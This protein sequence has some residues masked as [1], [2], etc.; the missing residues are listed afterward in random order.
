MKPLKILLPVHVFFPKHFYGTETY[1]L[2]LAKSLKTLGHDPVILTAI[3]C[4]EEGTGQLVSQ[5]H[6]DDLP[7]HVIDLNKMPHNRFKQTYYRPELYPI[8]KDLISTIQ[9]DIARVTHLINHTGTLLEVLKDRKIPTVSTLTDFFGICFNNKLERFDG[10]LCMGPNRHSTNCLGCYLCIAKQY[11]LYNVLQPFTKNRHILNTVT[12]L[13]QYAIK[14][15]GLRKSSLSGHIFDVTKRFNTLRHLYGQ[16]TSMVAPSDFLY[17]AYVK[18][19]FYP[20]RLKKINF[21]INLDLLEGYRETRKKKNGSTVFGYIGQISHHKGVDLLVEAFNR[22][23]GDNKKLKIF[24]PSDQ[25]PDYMHQLHKK[26]DANQQIEFHEP[27]PREKLAKRL[28]AIDILVIPS[29]WYEN[30]PLV[31]LYALATRTPVIATD[32]KGM[33]EFVKNDYNG[34]T[35]KKNDVVDLTKKMEKLIND[36]KTIERLSKN[37]NYTKDNID[38]AKEVFSIYQEIMSSHSTIHP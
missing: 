12:R 11:P 24:G 7:V 6:Y 16:Y 37:A 4:G 14:I 3:P 8:L 13:L 33:S 5:Y 10:A 1:T 38:H 35:F 22:L 18:N 2:D 34:F 21:G 26:A 36:P 19:R 27:F 9:P 23:S 30:S 31:L 20:E 15:P 28:A 25:D 32:V 17:D 29:R